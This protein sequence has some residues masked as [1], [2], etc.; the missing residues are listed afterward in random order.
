MLDRFQTKPPIFPS[1]SSAEQIAAWSG[2]CTVD[3]PLCYLGLGVRAGEQSDP[4]SRLSYRDQG[5]SSHRIWI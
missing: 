2:A 3:P 1:L 5:G 4:S